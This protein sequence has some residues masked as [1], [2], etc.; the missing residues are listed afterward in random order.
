MGFRMYIHP[1]Y[2]IS[3]GPEQTSPKFYGYVKGESLPSV[4][5]LSELCPSKPCE[6]DE[7]DDGFSYEAIC[8]CGE[9]GPFELTE[10][11]YDEFINLYIEDLKEFH[12]FDADDGFGERFIEY[13][14]R[15]KEVPGDKILEWG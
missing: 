10:E 3:F 1:T 13:A 14:L 12:N 11:Q 15:L 4:L 6:D 8:C 7:Y 9:Y 2:P 5:Y